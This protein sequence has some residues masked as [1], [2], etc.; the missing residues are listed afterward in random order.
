MI[1]SF[2]VS[3]MASLPADLFDA[4]L[5]V[6][7]VLGHLV[8]FAVEDLP[9]SAHRV[10]HRYLPPLAPG[11]HLR[12]AERLTEEPLNAARP[13]D[14]LFILRRRFVHPGDAAHALRVFE[15]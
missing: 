1:S 9:E 4:A 10:R 5:H 6:E 13:E 7:V 14:G 15:L 8:V 12:R 3:G 2:K 11:E